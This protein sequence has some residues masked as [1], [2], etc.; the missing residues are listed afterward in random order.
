MMQWWPIVTSSPT[1]IA[2]GIPICV[3]SPMVSVGRSL[4]VSP[5]SVMRS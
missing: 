2:T 3:W 4:E 5:A 1:M